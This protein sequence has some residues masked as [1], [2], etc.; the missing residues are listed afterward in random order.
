MGVKFTYE[1]QDKP[2]GLAQAFLIGENFIGGEPVAMILGD[3]IFADDFSEDIKNFKSGAKVFAKE[4]SDPKR[5][6]VVE[7][8]AN[9][10]ALSIAISI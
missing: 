2:E 8:D 4:V 9:F 10:K 7:F 6:G 3:N 5:F 1:I